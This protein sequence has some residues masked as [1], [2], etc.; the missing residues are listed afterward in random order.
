MLRTSVSCWA[1]AGSTGRRAGL[2]WGF[3]GCG[4]CFRWSGW[5]VG[6]GD[7]GGGGAGGGVRVAGV[8]EGAWAFRLAGAVPVP[9]DYR[10]ELAECA[11]QGG[12]PGPAEA[13]G[14]PDGAAG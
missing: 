11:G 8:P 7:D 13:D 9:V 10:A 14:G 12:V 4:G 2:S 5:L 3:S 6:E 1:A